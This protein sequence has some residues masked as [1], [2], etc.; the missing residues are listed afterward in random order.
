MQDAMPDDDITITVDP[1]GMLAILH[2]PA[3]TSLPASTLLDRMM[4][5]NVIGGIREDALRQAEQPADADRDLA[6][7][8]GTPAIQPVDARIEMMVHFGLRLSEGSDHKIDFHEQGRFHEINAGDVLARLIPKQPGTPGRTVHGKELPV[9]EPRDADMSALA[10]EA[11]RR[12]GFDL[13]AE[14]TGMVVRR[15][16]G[17][18]DVM[19]E[20]TIDSDLNM[21]CGNL[22]TR[23]PV[24]IKGDVIAG[25]TLKSAANV[26][27]TGVI[28]DARISVKGD[29][30]CGGILPGKLRVKAHGNLTTKHITRREVKCGNL[31]VSSDIR[32]SIVY[33]TGSIQAKL[34]VASR[35]HCGGSLTCDELGNV[36]ELGGVVQ[37]GVNPLAIALWRLAAREHETIVAEVEEAKKACKRLALWVKQETDPDKLQDCAA[38]LK[39]ALANYDNRVKR[40]GECENIL[41]N[42]TLRTGNNLEATI[43]VNQAVHPGTE[44]RIG[45]EAKLTVTKAMGK[46]TF[47]LKDGKITWD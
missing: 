36:D 27:V 18:L 6:V 25:F 22:T 3:H 7:A 15:H 37:I 13:I 4:R 44:I 35:V 17:H 34:I 39:L 30:T 42:A 38:K 8:I 24:S 31:V 28:E 26:T 16:D 47:R 20:V 40:L 1:A 21:R 2:L 33:A 45:T 19:P 5:V 41:N 9:G 29:L 43:V 11:T 10:G 12:Q 46:T 14:R 23:L 32:G